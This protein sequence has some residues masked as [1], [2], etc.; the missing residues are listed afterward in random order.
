MFCEWPTKYLLQQAPVKDAI[1]IDG[2]KQNLWTTGFSVNIPTASLT[3]AAAQQTFTA[4]TFTIDLVGE[5]S[6]I[7]IGEKEIDRAFFF[8]WKGAERACVFPPAPEVA[9][10]RTECAL[11]FTFWLHWA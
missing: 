7:V 9:E 1:T 11:I 5:L 8:L 10:S 3:Q 2:K 6:K 4:Q